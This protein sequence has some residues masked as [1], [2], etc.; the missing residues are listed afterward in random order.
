MEMNARHFRLGLFVVTSAFLGMGGVVVLGAGQLF[1]ERIT[2]ETYVNESV[3]GL[4]A[5]APVKFR[6]VK[7]GEVESIDF[8]EQRY[9]S[10]EHYVVILI[11]YYPDMLGRPERGSDF[12]AR[13]RQEIAHGLRIRLASQ[14]L[15]GAMYLEVDYFDPER[16]APLPIDWEPAAFY[17]P[18]VKS[19]GLRLAERAEN[20][21]A[22]LDDAEIDR[23]GGRA[24]VLLEE[25]TETVR[26]LEPILANLEGATREI[27]DLIAG[28]RRAIDEDIAGNVRMVLGQLSDTLRADVQPTLETVHI[29]SR[30][31]PA[32]MERLN[33]SLRRLERSVAGSEEDVGETLENLRVISD[34]LREITESARKYSSHLIL[35]GPPPRLQAEEP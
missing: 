33:R 5:G 31:L 9:G 23:I 7:V 35:G 1:R 12:A 2:V 17:V 6:G 27:P 34:D 16:N 14:G 10:H 4:D 20:V 26:R 29:A 11:A 21:V 8:A 25:L 13:L 18:S 22:A 15:T 28:A 3:Q 32:T 30:D 24:T 19:T